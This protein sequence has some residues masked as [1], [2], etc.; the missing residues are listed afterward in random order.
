MLQ[1]LINRSPDLARLRD[2]GYEVDVVAGYLIIHHIPY[3]NSNREVKIG[4]LIST[5]SLNDDITIKPDT[6][7]IHFMG[8]YPCNNDG[9]KITAI[10]HATPNQQIDDSLV[11]NFS[12]SNKPPSGYTDYYEKIVTYAEI[13]SCQARSIDPTVSAKTFNVIADKEDCSV[14]QYFDSNSSRA[15]ISHFNKKFKGHKIGIIGLG[16]TGSYVLDL[17]AKTPVDEIHIFDGDRFFQHNSFRSVGA[18]SKERLNDKLMKVEYFK[19]IYSNIHNVI[20]PH[21]EFLTEENIYLLDGLTYV[22]ICIDSNAAKRTILVHLRN[23]NIPFIDSGLGVNIVDEN[24]IGTIR[25][26]TGTSSKMDHIPLR[27][28]TENIDENEYSTNIQIADLNSLNAALAVIKWK[29]MLGFYQDLKNEH[30]STYS[31]NTAQLLNEDI[32]T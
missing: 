21:S 1:Q 15:N 22:F 16:G 14:F 6:H 17:V 10:E 20:I 24:L 9:T 19:S 3:V 26:T 31:I 7:V 2:E 23:H 27:I 32:A 29:K 30:H 12:F 25:V 11:M 18:I 4:K 13:I 8:E 5:L 28:G